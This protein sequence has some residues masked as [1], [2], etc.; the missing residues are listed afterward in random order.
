LV[1]YYSSKDVIWLIVR[2][3]YVG[4]EEVIICRQAILIFILI[5]FDRIFLFIFVYGCNIGNYFG[6][7][8]YL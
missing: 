6:L 5:L 7:R 2:L 4:A 1:L 3:Y 8:F